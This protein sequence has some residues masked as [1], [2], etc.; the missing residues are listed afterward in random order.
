MQL[1]AFLIVSSNIEPYTS[2]KRGLI[3]FD[4]R[5]VDGATSAAAALPLTGSLGGELHL[6]RTAPRRRSTPFPSLISLVRGKNGTLCLLQGHFVCVCMGLFVGWG[7]MGW[8]GGVI[9][10]TM[11]SLTFTRT[12]THT[13]V[14]REA[15]RTVRESLK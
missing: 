2:P 15:R 14:L 9:E 7:G 13:D 10:L 8:Y 3:K 4:L 5:L 11:N 1:P 6:Q 12:Q